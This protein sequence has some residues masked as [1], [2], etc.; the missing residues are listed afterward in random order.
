MTKQK[1]FK[2][3]VRE[4][5]AKTQESYST[6]RRQLL[7]RATQAAV[8]DPPV[9]IRPH[10]DEVLRGRTGRTW[11]EWFGMLDR[12]SAA[13]RRHPEIAR[14]LVTEHGVGGWW[15]QSITVAYEQARGMRAP[16]QRSDGSFEVSVSKTIDVPVDRLFAAFVSE[17]ERER[18]LPDTPFRIRSL[19]EP[20]VLRADWEDGTTRLAVHFTDKGPAKSAVVVVHQRL[21]DS[22]AADLARSMW[23]D[24]LALL[25]KVLA[26]RP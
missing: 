5:A 24:Q 18:W 3:K 22:A 13:E 4:R 14:W 7:A 2:R 10:S 12:W 21:A 15:A 20:T 23:R 26:E 1:T 16:G 6:A 25:K 17:A 19:R 9:A 8:A 11:D